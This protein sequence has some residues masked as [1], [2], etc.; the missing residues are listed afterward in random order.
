MTLVCTR[1][2]SLSRLDC[3]R[4]PK[5]STHVKAY[6]RAVSGTCVDWVLNELIPAAGTFG[7]FASKQATND[8]ART[9]SASTTLQKPL[10]NQQTS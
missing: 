10:T 9:A 5:I 1:E 8:A 4:L 7:I 2:S 6:L 3:G